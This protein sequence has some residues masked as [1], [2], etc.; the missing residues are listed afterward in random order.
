MKSYP[1]NIKKLIREYMTEAYERELHRELSKLEVSFSQWQHDEIGSGE[2]SYRLHQYEVGPSR[3]LYKKYNSG[4]ADLNVAYAIVVG[5]LKRE[6]VPPELLEAL[7]GPLNLFESIE[8]RGDL[9]KPD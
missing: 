7:E 6:E 8:A 4:E 2:L 1:K 3:E 9:Q 5:I